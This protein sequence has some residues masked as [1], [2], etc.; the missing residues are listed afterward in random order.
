MLDGLHGPPLPQIQNPELSHGVDPRPRILPGQLELSPFL[1]L[2]MRAFGTGAGPRESDLLSYLLF[3]ADF[4]RPLIELG[5]RDAAAHQ[6]QLAR[7][8]CDDPM[9]DAN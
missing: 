3:D 6:E 5:Y 2:F 1:R 8:F 4:A 7:F 9:E